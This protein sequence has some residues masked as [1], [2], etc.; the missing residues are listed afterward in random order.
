MPAAR[1][2][3]QAVRAYAV[4][5]GARGKRCH[6][7]TMK[8]ARAQLTEA[9]AFATID[10]L[11]DGRFLVNTPPLPDGATSGICFQNCKFDRGSLENFF[12]ALTTPDAVA[13]MTI[14]DD[15]T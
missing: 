10:E 6:G 9:I 3:L 14:P 15:D 11:P 2:C 4:A 7:D 5:V 13:T 12:K 8:D 1:S